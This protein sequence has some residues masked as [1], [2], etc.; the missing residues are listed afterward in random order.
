MNIPGSCYGSSGPASTNPETGDP[1]G[2]EFPPVTIADWTRAQRR[3]LDDL[4]ITTLAAV[5]GG[6]SAG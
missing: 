6:A 5:V 1:Y 3:L 4:G 2:T